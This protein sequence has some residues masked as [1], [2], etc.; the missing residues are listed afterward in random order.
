MNPR[1]NRLNFSPYILRHFGQNSS[2]YGQTLLTY[3]RKQI[4]NF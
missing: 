3:I 2:R 1:T 4:D